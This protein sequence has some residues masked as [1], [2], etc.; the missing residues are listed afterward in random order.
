MKET[1]EL[2]KVEEKVEEEVEEEEEVGGGKFGEIG[3]PP[4]QR[5]PA[6]GDAVRT[7]FK[8]SDNF[9]SVK[10]INRQ[11][12]FFANICLLKWQGQLVFI[13]CCAMRE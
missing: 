1:G 12:M 5:A 9:D 6:A 3:E 2:S 10:Y 11:N 7:H 13:N 4:S 8:Q